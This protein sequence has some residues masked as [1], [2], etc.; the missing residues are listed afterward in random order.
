MGEWYG[1]GV[2]LSIGMG[3][4]GKAPIPVG[5]RT[6]RIDECDLVPLFRTWKKL[7]QKL[8]HSS[9]Q[10]GRTELLATHDNSRM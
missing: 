5:L 3:G 10:T 1:R 6:P 7:E 4:I 2:S 9:K 8:E